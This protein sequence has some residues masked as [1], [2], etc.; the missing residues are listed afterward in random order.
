MSK[1]KSN[2]FDK[3]QITVTNRLGHISKVLWF[4]RCQC[5]VVMST[6]QQR[7][8]KEKNYQLQT[9]HW[10]P[11]EMNFLAKYKPIKELLE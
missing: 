7:F 9:K 10:A 11:K 1:K 3:G 5:S 4:V 8:K 6:Y 2:D